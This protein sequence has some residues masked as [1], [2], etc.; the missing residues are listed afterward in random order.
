MDHSASLVGKETWRYPTRP[1]PSKLTKLLTVERKGS[2]VVTVIIA[3]SQGTRGV[4]VGS[5]ISISSRLNST[6]RGR[7]ELSFLLRQV[8]PVH[9]SSVQAGEIEGRA[10]ASHHQGADKNMEHEVITK[11]DI[12]ALIKALKESG[13]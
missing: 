6:K 4:N 3:R 1:R 7:E 12:D 13:Y 10:L 8:R 9:Q 11:S 2:S 5:Y